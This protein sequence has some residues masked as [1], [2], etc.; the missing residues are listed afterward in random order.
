M[1]I[2]RQNY[3]TFLIDYLEGNLDPLTVSEVLLFLKKHPDIQQEFVDLEIHTIDTEW[4]N[5][6][7]FTSLKKPAFPTVQNQLQT[8]LIAELE[9]DLS[10]EDKSNLAL[11]QILY[12]ELERDREL[13]AYTINK[14]ELDV[15]YPNKKELKK[16]IIF[17]MPNFRYWQSAAAIL[18][19]V[20]GLAW[21]LVQQQNN[22]QMH[23]TQSANQTTPSF[24]NDSNG[25]TNNQEKAV[26]RKQYVSNLKQKIKP[27]IR[28][29]PLPI[30]IENRI[31]AKP[32]A[33]SMAMNNPAN[34]VKLQNREITLTPNI[35]LV[36][37]DSIPTKASHISLAQLL[38]QKVSAASIVLQ[39]KANTTVANASKSAGIVVELD[40][41]NQKISKLAFAPLGFEWSQSK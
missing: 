40:E 36:S 24:S 37:N 20:F 14:P 31:L 18:I 5:I 12:P 7:D 2:T 32:E 38:F 3:E 8:L 10:T 30:L 41:T 39:N 15:V 19:A 27:V 35:P 34:L 28:R 21:Y 4:A 1:R 13:Y 6:P 17:Q 29:K 22:M 26:L 33:I 25:E 16:N 9:G 11:H 23:T